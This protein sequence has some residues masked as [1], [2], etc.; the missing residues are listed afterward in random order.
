MPTTRAS[1]GE[2]RSAGLMTIEDVLRELQISRS[3]LDAW[4]RSKR[5]PAFRRLPNGQLRLKRIELDKWLDQRK[6]AA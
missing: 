4:R 3:T 2:I 1:V 6:K 5:F